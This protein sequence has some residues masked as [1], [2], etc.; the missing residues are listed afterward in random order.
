MRGSFASSASAMRRAEISR[1]LMGIVRRHAIFLY[2]TSS[3]NREGEVV[4]RCVMLCSASIQCPALQ[5][6][7]RSDTS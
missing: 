1:Y 6:A 3:V 5:V 7:G 2:V 4:L